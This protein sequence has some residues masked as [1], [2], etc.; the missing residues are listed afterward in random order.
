M[1]KIVYLI[2]LVLLLILTA[3][4][5]FW[6]SM[7]QIHSLPHAAIAI[8]RF[9]LVRAKHAVRAQVNGIFLWQLQS[10]CCPLFL[11]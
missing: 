4:F 3:I 7:A 8:E 11:R 2:V 5:E 9:A 10:F 1:P 6:S